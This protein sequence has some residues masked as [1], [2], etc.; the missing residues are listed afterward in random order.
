MKKLK[1]YQACV[2]TSTELF[3]TCVIAYS[4]R[5]ATKELTTWITDSE[6]NNNRVIYIREINTD[7]NIKISKLF[8]KLYEFLD[9]NY[10]DDDL[11][12]DIVLNLLHIPT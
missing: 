10:S 7:T 2:K 3:T 6:N 5:A 1:L 11:E 4:K 9:D 12:T 8:D